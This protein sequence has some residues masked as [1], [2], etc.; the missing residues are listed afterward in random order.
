MCGICGVWNGDGAPVEREKID[1]MVRSLD[2]R[3]PDESGTHVRGAAGL[4]HTRLS[5]IDLET[6]SQ[7]MCNENGRI[8][9]TFNGEIFNY[10][11]LRHRLREKGHRFRTESDTE[12]LIH[13]Y[14]EYGTDL[15]PMLN[16][17]WALAIWDERRGELL[18]C[19]DRFG[20]C[21]LYY[22]RV[23]NR[24]LFASE[25]KALLCDSRISGELDPCGLA[26]IFT[27]WTSIAPQTVFR[28][29][30]EIVPGR[31]MR[32]FGS[33]GEGFDK[34]KSQ[35][36]TYWEPS[37]PAFSRADRQTAGDTA[38]E[39]RDLLTDAVRL[40]FTRS[41]VPVAA[42]LSGGIDSSITAALMRRVTDAKLETFSLR[43]AEREYDE[44]E[45]QRRMVDLLGS[46][47]AEVRVSAR[48][49]G[50]VFP[51]VVRHAERPLLR[52]APA[53]MYLLSK[54]VRDSGYK[55]VVTGEG[56]DEVFGGYDIFRETMLRRFIAA[57]PESSKR[58]EFI[59]MLY[60]WL[61]R[62]PAEVPAF[63]R[64]FFRKSLDVEDPALSHRMRWRSAASVA[65]LLREDIRYEVEARDTEGEFLERMPPEAKEWHPLSRAQWIEMSSLLPGYLLGSQGDRMLMA[66]G[67]EGRFP[68]L[69]PV[70]VDRTSH[71]PPRYKIMG[72]EEKYI[73]KHAFSDLVPAEILHRSKQPYRAPDASSFFGERI[74]WVEE[75]IEPRALRASEIFD[76]KAVE[77]LAAKCREKEGREMSN[78]DNMAVTAVLS[79]L[80]LQRLTAR[81]S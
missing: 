39:L 29:V 77:N 48:D 11:E 59:P 27:F 63:A 35:E 2:H 3:G 76:P 54:L 15:F 14:E 43:F 61:R 1:A 45:A 58:S 38:E 72:M 46:D 33:S 26:E 23:G 16:G 17:Q 60:P 79:T 30:E 69:D 24:V 62:S 53:P 8:W 68:F 7:P 10:V 25:V 66:N 19:R 78:F 32:F 55:V 18:L 5:V 9:I 67:V 74:E 75:L 34:G 22:A 44:G 70:L 4:G 65:R 6:G 28:G 52:T 20:I 42:Y 12:V 13:G 56:G 40:R 21:P 57:H 47:H 49:I 81:S 71:V 51:E 36:E 73:L 64:S 80:L 31:W 50:E 41:D 37:F